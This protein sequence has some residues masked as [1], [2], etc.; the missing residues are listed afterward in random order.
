MIYTLGLETF[1][2]GMRSVYGNVPCGPEKYASSL[3]LGFHMCLLDQAC[4]WH[5]LTKC[6][7]LLWFLNNYV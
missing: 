2:P 7:H 1:R 5:M 6:V 4:K 3:F